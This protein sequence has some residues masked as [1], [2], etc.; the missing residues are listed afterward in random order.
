MNRA[1]ST[2]VVVV[3]R[4][5]RVVGIITALRLLRD[6]FPMNKRSEEV[7]ASQLMAPFYRIGPSPSTKEAARN[8][9]AHNIT[10]LGMFEDGEFL[11]WVSLTDLTREFS[12]RRLVDALR[13]NEE[14]EDTDFLCPNCRDAFLEAETNADGEIQLW[15]CP[16]CGNAL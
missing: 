8:M 15:V 1:N 11:G 4:D 16:K 2:G 7:K 12:R 13:S 9:L 3:D 10:R 14:P 6:F 5:N